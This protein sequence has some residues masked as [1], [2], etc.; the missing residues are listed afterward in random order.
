MGKMR[1]TIY[2]I[3]FLMNIVTV[4]LQNLIKKN[5]ELNKKNKK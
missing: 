2:Q 1:E 5:K 3:I 4:S